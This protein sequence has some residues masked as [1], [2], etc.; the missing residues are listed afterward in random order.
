MENV[1]YNDS[2]SNT[3]VQMCITLLQP[4]PWPQPLQH[5]GNAIKKKSLDR[6]PYMC[7]WTIPWNKRKVQIICMESNLQNRDPCQIALVRKCSLGSVCYL[8]ATILALLHLGFL[9]TRC[10]DL[11][12]WGYHIQSTAMYTGS[13][14]LAFLT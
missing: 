10:Q 11:T 1:L 6:T 4:S 14:L 5:Q 8:H 3:N 9:F 13:I 12:N 7:P 2:T